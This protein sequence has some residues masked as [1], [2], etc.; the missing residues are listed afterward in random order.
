MPNSCMGRYKNVAVL[1]V[2]A[3]AAPK[4]ISER[5]KGV[6]RIVVHYGPQN[7]GKTERCAYERTLRHAKNLANTLANQM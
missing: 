4:M 5:S 7:V 1:E 6:V 2:E 3:G